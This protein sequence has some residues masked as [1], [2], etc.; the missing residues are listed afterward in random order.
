[1][2]ISSRA[3]RR[4]LVVATAAA[5]IGGG[6]TFAAIADASPTDDLQAVKAATARF[7]SFDQ[8]EKT[9]YSI[10]GEPC[11][12]SPLGTM[13]IHAVNKALMDDP[14]VDPL[15]PE[16]L[17]YVPSAEGSLKLVGIEYWMRDADGDLST[18]GDRPLC[19]RSV[20]RRADAGAQPDDGRGRALPLRSAL[21]RGVSVQP[22]IGLPVSSSVFRPLST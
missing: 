11:V 17:L 20:L 5:V 2:R 19:A 22:F 12:A 7:N 15:Q 14:A 8:A 18:A 10:V 3:G 9:G 13:G 16:I 6:A 21:P 1:M 4:A